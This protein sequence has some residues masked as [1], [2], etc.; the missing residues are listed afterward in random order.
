MKAICIDSSNKP[1]HISEYEWIEEGAV[2]TITEI[3]E[4]GLQN[5]KL[6]IALKEVELTDA[7]APYKYYSL[8]RFLIIPETLNSNLKALK[9]DSLK[10]SEIEVDIYAE[11]ADLTDS[12]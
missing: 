3:V 2:Y 5:N 1:E 6:G 8:E 4:M 10:D 11:D 12:I 9:E 7:S